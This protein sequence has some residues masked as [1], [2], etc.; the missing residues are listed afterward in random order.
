MYVRKNTIFE[1]LGYFCF[2]AFF[3]LPQKKKTAEERLIVNIF[4]TKQKQ[5]AFVVFSN[6]IC[7]KTWNLVKNVFVIKW[8]ISEID[9]S[10]R[11]VWVGF[12]CIITKASCFIYCYSTFWYMFQ[13]SI[14]FEARRNIYTH[15]H[16][17]ISVLEN[18]SASNIF[19]LRFKNKIFLAK[20]VRPVRR[21]R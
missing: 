18:T 3:F 17:S 14:S 8:N 7:F 4:R 6:E 12:R 19:S 16:T 20:V 5:F 15:K 2:G 13:N 1:N 9:M 11:N 10:D 21:V